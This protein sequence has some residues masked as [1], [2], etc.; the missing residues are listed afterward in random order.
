MDNVLLAKEEGIATIT[1]NRPDARNSLDGKT[2]EE[3][4]IAIEDVRVDRDVRVVIIT[5][6]GKAFCAG[7]DLKYAGTMV[8]MT[9][10]DVRAFIRNIQQIFSLERLEKPV[11][12]AVNGYAMGNGCDIALACDFRIASENAQFEMTYTKLGLIPD[13][14]GTFRLPRLIGIEKAKELIYTG[15]RVDAKE[16]ERIGLVSKVV[17][18]EKLDSEVKEFA[19]KLAKGAPIAIGLAK[20]AINNGIGTDLRSA[21][22]YEVYCQSLCLQTKDVAEAMAAFM[23]KREPKFKGR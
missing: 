7:L 22:E 10:P 6:A 2:Y 21:I 3:L 13:L 12:A 19:E 4:G 1:I 8:R 17:P 16:A 11:I 5:G 18:A 15:R 23:G 20:M 14:G 9:P